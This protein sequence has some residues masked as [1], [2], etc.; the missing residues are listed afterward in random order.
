MSGQSFSKHLRALLMARIPLYHPQYLLLSIMLKL[1]FYDHSI[2]SSSRIFLYYFYH[3]II[4]LKTVQYL[5]SFFPVPTF[6][7]DLRLSQH[8]TLNLYKPLK[9]LDL[10]LYLIFLNLCL[11]FSHTITIFF[12][13]FKPRETVNSRKTIRLLY[14]NFFMPRFKNFHY[15]FFFFLNL[16]FSSSIATS[17]IIVK[18]PLGSSIFSISFC[19]FKTIID[20]ISW[21][22][23]R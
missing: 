6:P 15:N 8:F 20:T 9:S 17:E 12:T 7:L 21:V 23:R 16:W 3:L 13:S 22:F 4:M 18:M 1:L 2:F 14:V 11:V 5:S 19:K 10:P